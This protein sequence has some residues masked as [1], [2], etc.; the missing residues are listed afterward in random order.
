MSVPVGIVL[1]G[2]SAGGV[3]AVQEILSGLKS[4]YDLPTVVVQH[5]PADSQIDPKQIY[6][7]SSSFHVV[8]ATDKMPLEK[9]FVYFAPPG[10]HLLLE[11]HVQHIALSQDPA[12]NFSRPSIDVTFESAAL[13][14]GA[15][16]CGVLLTGANEDGARG[17]QAIQEFGG[18]TVV[19]DPQEAEVATMPLAAMRLN[20]P[21]FIGKLNEISRHLSTL[22]GGQRC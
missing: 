16:V 7:R 17:L 9:G 4:D 15:K 5:L 11:P 14:Y 19:Q 18:H 8:E 12:V 21:N 6:G 3:H 1:I 13:A 10:Y 2:A 22:T 20:K